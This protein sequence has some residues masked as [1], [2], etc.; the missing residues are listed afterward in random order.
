[1]HQMPEPSGEPLA[2]L[3][4]EL[5]PHHVHLPTSLLCPPLLS[6]GFGGLPEETFSPLANIILFS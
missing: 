3:S 2:I 6:T 1:M 5:V 4:P